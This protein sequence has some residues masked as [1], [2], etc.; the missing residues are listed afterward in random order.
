MR[1]EPP[2]ELDIEN[3]TLKEQLKV[4]IE[5]RLLALAEGHSDLTGASVAIDQPAHGETDYLYQ[6][7]VVVYTRPKN[8][9]ASEKMETAE[10]A[11]RAAL[12]AIERQVREKRDKLGEPWKRPDLRAGDC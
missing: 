9:Y 12:Q 2:I 4:E 6:A 5:N 1:D 11:M 3:P 10:G 8:I 7:R